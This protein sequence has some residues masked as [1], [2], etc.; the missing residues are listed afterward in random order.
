MSKWKT[1]LF[2]FIPLILTCLSLFYYHHEV[3]GCLDICFFSNNGIGFP[4]AVI[5]T[6]YVYTSQEF[7]NKLVNNGIS[8]FIMFFID[9]LFWVLFRLVIFY[10]F[11]YLLKILFRI[12][13]AITTV[14]F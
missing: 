14:R 2:I 1:K 9:Y 3:E 4:L 8:V 11:K 7:F 10:L 12:A 5:D 13:H 6:T